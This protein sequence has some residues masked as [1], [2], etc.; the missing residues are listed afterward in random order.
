ML[1]LGHSLKSVQTGRPILIYKQ[2]VQQ[3]LLGTNISLFDITYVEK[4]LHFWDSIWH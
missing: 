4:D 1:N 2:L 3:I